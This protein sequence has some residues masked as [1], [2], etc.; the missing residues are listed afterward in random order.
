MAAAAD[1]GFAE[2]PRLLRDASCM[3]G[4]L[5]ERARGAADR[6]WRAPRCGTGPP[7]IQGGAARHRLRVDAPGPYGVASTI[8]PVGDVTPP[9]GSIDTA[10]ARGS[11]TEG[12]TSN[13]PVTFPCASDSSSP[14]LTGPLPVRNQS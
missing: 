14:A 7:L 2:R 9:R 13:R 11:P 4:G 1:A 6:A 8:G 12:G 10:N 5:V 3:R